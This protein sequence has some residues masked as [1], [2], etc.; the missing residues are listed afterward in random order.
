M[1]TFMLGV[2]G[3]V[4]FWCI[5]IPI[6]FVIAMMVLK[7]IFPN[8]LR[9]FTENKRVYNSCWGANC[10]SYLFAALMV[11]VYTLFWYII[12]VGF[13]FY[14]LCCFIFPAFKTL[15]IKLIKA[16]PVITINKVE[17]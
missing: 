6:D 9:P 4:M 14:K 13:I 7:N 5:F 3:S 11:L 8:A 17:E 16:I 10:D 12:I 15:F 2:L 1:I